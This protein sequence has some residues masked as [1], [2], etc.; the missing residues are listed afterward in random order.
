MCQSDRIEL[1]VAN[2]ALTS[3]PAL[4]WLEASKPEYGALRG[5]R[6]M[7]LSA[8]KGLQPA[9]FTFS[10]T[11]IILFLLEWLLRRASR[12]LNLILQL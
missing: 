11:A 1:N 10:Q 9:I 2:S 12:V 3:K 6:V 5:I 7:L 4:S 8:L